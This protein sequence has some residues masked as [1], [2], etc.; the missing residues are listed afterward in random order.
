MYLHYNFVT[1]N[2][3]FYFRLFIYDHMLTFIMLVPQHIQ[4]VPSTQLFGLRDPKS[5]SV[6]RCAALSPPFNM[7]PRVK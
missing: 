6:F 5:T 7:W 1:I 2:I 4:Q 3:Y